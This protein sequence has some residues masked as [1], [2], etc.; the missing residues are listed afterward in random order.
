MFEQAFRFHVLEQVAVGAGAQHADHVALVVGD[1]EHHDARVDAVLA[2]CA[3]GVEAVHAL[4]VEVEQDHVRVEFGAQLQ[5]FFATAGFADH[6]QVV[7][8][9]E[10]LDHALAHHRVVV[11]QQDAGRSVGRVRGHGVVSLR[12]VLDSGCGLNSRR[13]RVPRGTRDVMSRTAPRVWL[14]SRMMLRP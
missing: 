3:Q 6:A 11:D 5:R 7:F 13:T 9:F 1:G 14:R 2:Q 10:Q 8:Q 12:V 4:H